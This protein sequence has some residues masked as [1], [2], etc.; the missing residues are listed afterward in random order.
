ML[1]FIFSKTPLSFFVQSLW[2]D[3][4]FSYLLAKKNIIEII[5]LTAKDYNPPLY[6]LI[7]HFWIKIFGSSEIALRGLSLIFYWATI[8]IVFLFLT[9]IFKIKNK[10]LLFLT[11]MLFIINPLLTYY[12]FE[13]RMYTLLAFF[14]ILSSYA[15]LKESKKIYFLSLIFGLS[16]HY[17]MFFIFLS[18]LI[19]YFIFKRKFKKINLNLFIYPLICFLIW[20]TFVFFQN[21]QLINNDFWIKKQEIKDLKNFAAILFT[22][23]EKDFGFDYK[24]ITNFSIFLFL[25]IVTLFLTKKGTLLEKKVV[26]FYLF[27][28]GFIIPFIIF[29]V[30][31]FKPIFLP[32]YLIGQTILLLLFIVYLINKI[33]KKIISFLILFVFLYF[34]FDYQKLQINYRKKTDYK[35]LY[36]EIKSLLKKDDLVYVT[37][38]LDFFVAQYYIDEKRVKIYGKTYEEIPNYVGKILIPKKATVYNLPFYPEKAFIVNNDSYTIQS[39]F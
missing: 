34:S 33:D 29:I 30:S 14:S 26:F 9:E 28:S 32:R 39:N 2:R 23:Y 16:T 37:S 20:M 12:A 22:G 10:L 25:I 24:K 17:F 35:K 21:H 5:F 13:A 6:Y 11:L 4:A 7:L 27:F 31:F 3:E 8:Y 19:T 36:K 38:E 15:F 18:Q 1:S